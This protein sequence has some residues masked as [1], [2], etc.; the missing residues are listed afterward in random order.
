M[1]Y[2]FASRVTATWP[3][4]F[5]D[6]DLLIL[7]GLASRSKSP[8]SPEA[9]LAALLLAKAVRLSHVALDLEDAA[10]ERLL[11]SKL[12]K[13]DDENENEKEKEPLPAQPTVASVQEGVRDLLAAGKMV[14]E[15]T[16]LNND[17]STSTA[18]LI[19]S[20]DGE[21]QRYLSYRRYVEDEIVLAQQLVESARVLDP[22]PDVDLDSLLQLATD[23]V[24][25]SA[26]GLAALRN[27]TERSL[28]VITGGPGRGKT[29]ILATLLLGLHEQARRTG[30]PFTVA[31]AAPTAKAAVRMRGALRDALS[32]NGV[33][34]QDVA[35]TL[36][37]DE[38]SGS[39]HRLLQIRPDQRISGRTLHHDLVLVDE[40]S[41][42]DLGL[43]AKLVS[44]TRGH[45][46]LVGDANQLTAVNVGAA[47]RD[48][49]DGARNAGAGHLVTELTTNYRSVP[50][51]D[52]L[53]EAVRSRDPQSV[54]EVVAAH[55][56]HLKM[57]SSPSEAVPEVLPWARQLVT[58]A[59]DATIGDEQAL[60]HLH[61][62]AV[63]CATHE[64]VASVAWW[65]D[66]IK[67]ELGWR[68]S[69]DGGRFAV[70]TPVMVTRN[71]Q[72][73]S[74]DRSQLLANGDVGLVVQRD[75]AVAVFGAGPERQR[76]LS[77][78]GPA[79]EAWSIT[80]HKSQGSEYD[81]V[82]VSLPTAANALLSVELLYTAV[83]RA[84]S[85]VVIVAPKKILEDCLK[86]HVWRA[87]GLAERIV[88]RYHT[89]A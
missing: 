23:K 47:L 58:D 63:L 45:V 31:Y 30:R 52:A 8:L 83:T 20:T 65:R 25:L 10:L 38:R 87:S 56:A 78:L 76:P 77:Q 11:A 74:E 33:S 37:I 2:E 24:K 53:A 86:E 68:D 60:A 82:V 85:R 9:E 4:I 57:V 32:A 66:Q 49:I 21:R 42:C 40:V 64:G 81:T 14:A 72:R 62:V 41:M 3:G 29:T 36:H 18:L 54:L 15:T 12:W 48:L 6:Y 73:A 46:V 44:H 70:G 22:L 26:E 7:R 34:E 28:S 13:R 75:D 27:A 71:E 88:A 67:R 35:S 19:V 50:E 39:L 84:K 59:A 43:L 79:V 55:P 51:I 17:V 16:P 89:P 5:A 1:A 61:D 69:A 80:I